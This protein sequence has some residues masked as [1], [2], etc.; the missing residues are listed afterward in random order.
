MARRRRHQYT[1][2]H[3]QA[4]APYGAVAAAAAAAGDDDDVDV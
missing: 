3:G 4:T 1:R 2:T